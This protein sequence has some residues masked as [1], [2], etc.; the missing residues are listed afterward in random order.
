MLIA[1]ACCWVADP[2]PVAE[3]DWP[4]LSVTEFFPQ[5]SEAKIEAVCCIKELESSKFDETVCACFTEIL[6]PHE[7]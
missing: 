5:G 3:K 2:E 1:L 4:L 7:A 6:T